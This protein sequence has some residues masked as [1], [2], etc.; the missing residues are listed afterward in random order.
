[1]LCDRL[2]ALFPAALARYD[3]SPEHTT[4]TRTIPLDGVQL[5]VKF[6]IKYHELTSTLELFLQPTL[7]VAEIRLICHDCACTTTWNRRR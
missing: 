6:W 2:L 3:S 5:V 7:L 1:M 4:C